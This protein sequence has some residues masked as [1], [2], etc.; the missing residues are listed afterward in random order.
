MKLSWWGR[1]VCGAEGSMQGHPF[2]KA[3][4]AQVN[5]QDSG[6]VE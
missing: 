4:R 5:M 6:E 3:Q 2:V 1:G